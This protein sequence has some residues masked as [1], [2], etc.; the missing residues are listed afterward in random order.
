[1]ISH[2]PQPEPPPPAQPKGS[3]GDSSAAAT[4]STR[5]GGLDALRFVA[6][7]WVVFAHCGAF[8]LTE[9]LD[10][11]DTFALL[12]QGVY[13][14]LFAGV[15][16]VVVFF[17]ISGFC[18]HFPQRNG[19]PVPVLAY[20]VRRYL[21]IGIPLLVAVWLARPLEV[22]L[23]LFHNSILWSLAAELIYYTLYPVL[24]RLRARF[25]WSVLIGGA[26]LLSYVAVATHPGATDYTP[27]GVGLNW[28]ICLPCWLLGCRLAELHSAMDFQFQPA[29]IWRWRLGIWGLSWVCS[30][31]RFHSPL[32]YPWTMGVFALVVFHWLRREILVARLQGAH[33]L[34]EWAGQWSYAIYLVHLIVARG[35][36]KLTLPNL[37]PTLNWLVMLS[38]VLLGSF[39]FYR[40]VEW[41]SHLLARALGRKLQPARPRPS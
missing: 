24:L 36:G 17:V 2:T 4:E 11:R 29:H 18:V 7:L 5:V 8:P 16:A 35:F 14:N 27:Y 23:A 41:P 3:P 1:M 26:Y 6:A 25:G 30:V 33:P 39:L 31:L 40:L 38:F 34:L 13:G 9:G 32:G 20:L 37:G 21:R 22:N 10:R 12:V 15:P 19:A 28:L